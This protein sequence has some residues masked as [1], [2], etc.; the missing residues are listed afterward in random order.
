MGEA[1][2]LKAS[3]HLDASE[4]RGYA[5]SAAGKKKGAK[6]V[7]LRPPVRLVHG[8][9]GV[10][11]RLSPERRQALLT[12]CEQLGISFR[13]LDL[14]NIALTH[15]SF[16]AEFNQGSVPSN[17]RLEFLGDAVLGL[18]VS[19]Y[20]YHTYPEMDEGQ[21]TRIKAI[22]VSEPVLYGIAK[23]TWVGTIPAVGQGR[24]ED[25]WAGPPFRFSR[26]L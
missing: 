19:D 7:R 15:P 4:G 2:S 18:I 12:L 24:G 16:C 3:R 5:T 25:G 17:Q 23:K 22:S 10:T 14:L 1:R 26:R 9:N 6:K 8:R 13:R 11:L 20:L 21:L